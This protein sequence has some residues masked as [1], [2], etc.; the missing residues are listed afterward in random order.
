MH[1]HML[2]LPRLAAES[3]L[4]RDAAATR[5]TALA[6]RAELRPSAV[7]WSRSG[8]SVKY[9]RTFTAPLQSS[10]KTRM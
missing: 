10:A 9:A 2:A 7:D 3:F 6:P 8:T 5:S 4:E 1:A